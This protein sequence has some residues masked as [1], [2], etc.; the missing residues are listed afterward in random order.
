LK[1]CSQDVLIWVINKSRRFIK[2]DLPSF[3]D[4]PRHP[5]T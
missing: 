2:D 4:L 3:V 1:K 5:Q